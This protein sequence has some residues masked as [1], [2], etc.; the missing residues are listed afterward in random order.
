MAPRIDWTIWKLSRE[1]P[2]PGNILREPDV[3]CQCEIRPPMT[4]A[5]LHLLIRIKEKD[6][7]FTYAALREL[8]LKS[9]MVIP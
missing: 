5:A 3:V 2:L 8:D 4:A 9:G 7:S 1:A 6:G